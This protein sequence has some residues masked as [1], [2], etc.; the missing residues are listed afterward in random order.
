[1]P[2]V[3]EWLRK[4]NFESILIISA[5]FNSSLSR[6]PMH[7]QLY[8]PCKPITDPLINQKH[9]FSQME[10]VVQRADLSDTHWVKSVR[11]Q[12][13]SGS[14]F[15]GIFPHSDWIRRDTYL[16][17]FTPNAGKMLTRI[18]P[19]TDTFYAVTFQKPPHLKDL[20]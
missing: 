3:C 7:W 17:V 11:I 8:H 20:L 19:N 9:I 18:T 13:Y 5:K 12:S 6:R 10:Y 4:L 15:S 14:Y 16:S 1:M 2:G